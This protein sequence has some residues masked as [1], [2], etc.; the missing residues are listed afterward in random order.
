VSSLAVAEPPV[1]G[2]PEWIE[3]A[4][5]IKSGRDPL[6]LMTITQDRIMPVLVPGLLA[7]SNRARYFTFHPFL[8][9]EFER[10]ELPPDDHALSAFVRLREFEL[11]CAVQ[12]CPNGCGTQGWTTG[13]TCPP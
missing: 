3:P 10:R 7:L 4:L 6:G 1:A 13:R 12:L 11:A 5:Q 8:I 2:V 9:D